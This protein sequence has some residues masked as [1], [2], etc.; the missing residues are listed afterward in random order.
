MEDVKM[1][2]ENEAQFDFDGTVSDEE[3][4]SDIIEMTPEELREFIS[5]APEGTSINILFGKSATS[6]GE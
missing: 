2:G 5:N 4:V 3:L 1:Y 6:E